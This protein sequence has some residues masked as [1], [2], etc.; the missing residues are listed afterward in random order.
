MVTTLTE[1]EERKKFHEQQDEILKNIPVEFANAL[2]DIAWEQ[3]HSSGYS[4]V[5]MIVGD[6]VYRLKPAIAAYK[7]RIAKEVK[8]WYRINKENPHG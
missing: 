1:I 2:R 7:A 4:E 5:L 6:L 3:G 8:S